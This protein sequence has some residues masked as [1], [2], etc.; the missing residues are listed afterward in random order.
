MTDLEKTKLIIKKI[1]DKFGNKYDLSQIGI[2]HN[3][4][5]DKI[6]IICPKHGPFITTPKS[7]LKSKFGCKKCAY[8]LRNNKS[9][10]NDLIKECINIDNLIPLENPKVVDKNKLIGTVYCFINKTNNKLYFGETVKSDFNERFNEHRSKSKLGVVNYFYNAIRKYT[11][12]NFDK[13]IVF[14]TDV[15]DKTDENKEILNNIVN[16]K[17]KEFIKQFN[18]D[19]HQFGY[20]LTKGGDGIVGYKFTEETKKK[21][22]ILHSGENHWNYGNLNNK[23]SDIILQFD[24]DFNFIKEWPSMR[25]IE[26]ELGYATSNISRCCSNKIDT[27][28]SSIWV[29]KENYFEGYLQKYKSRAKCKSSDK[30]VLQFDFLGNKIAEYISGAEAARVLNIN[31]NTIT[32]A[33][34]GRDPQAHGFIWIYKEKFTEDI[35]KD[36][37]EKVKSCRFYKKIVSNLS[38]ASI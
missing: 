10:K 33:A 20:N 12:E 23:T 9:G 24:L 3:T 7:I 26:R 31:R 25:E 18:T 30:E 29:K 11:W 5:E 1:R 38:S 34:S 21:M 14:Q 19:N 4:E 36:K 17:E 37:L 28:K 16:K 15:Y 22:S 35:L 8:E 27:Y 32:A 6:T 2:I 13:I